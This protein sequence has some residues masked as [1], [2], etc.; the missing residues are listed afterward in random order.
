MN[1]Y[2]T[3]DKSP[4]PK[5]KKDDETYGS[6]RV[7]VNEAVTNNKFDLGRLSYSD[8]T[9]YC[10]GHYAPD[11]TEYF[12]GIDGDTNSSSSEDDF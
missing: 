4:Y 5:S 12:D 7:R 9:D 2:V 6:Y 3:K 1:N 10:R 8:Y 11:A